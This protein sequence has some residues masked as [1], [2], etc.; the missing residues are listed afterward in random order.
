MSDCPHQSRDYDAA[1]VKETGCESGGDRFPSVPVIKFAIVHWFRPNITLRAA[2]LLV[3]LVLFGPFRWWLRQLEFSRCVRLQINSVSK[4][5]PLP[6]P[7]RL[8]L[9][10]SIP[11]L[12]MSAQGSDPHPAVVCSPGRHTAETT[13]VAFNP[14]EMSP[15]RRATALFRQKKE[16]REWLS[17]ILDL[18]SC[19]LCHPVYCQCHKSL[20]AFDFIWDVGKTQSFFLHSAHMPWLMVKFGE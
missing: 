1:R 19:N 7:L 10:T 4:T 13:T 12:M 16:Q 3:C 17:S 11:S 8:L 15:H 5:G 20:R 18:S 2:A 6:W 14:G 9:K